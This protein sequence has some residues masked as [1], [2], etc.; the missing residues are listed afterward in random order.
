MTTALRCLRLTG[1]D[2]STLEGRNAERYR[3]AAWASLSNAGSRIVSMLLVVMSVHLTVPYL[4]TTRFGVWATFASMAAMLSLL[5][6]GIGNALVNRVAQAAAHGERHELQ[7]VVS[8]GSGLL[9]I[10]GF[11]A[12]ALLSIGA[13]AV[14]WERVF[15]LTDART[16]DE[17]R[18]AAVVFAV[19]FGINLFSTGLMRVLAG[20]QRMH[21]ANVVTGIAAALA[22]GTLWFAA[23][24]QAGVPWLIA[25]T[26]GLQSVVSLL[27]GVL[28]HRDGLWLR[29]GLGSAI[30]QEWR[31]LLNTGSLFMLLQLGTMVGWASDS[32]ILASLKGASEVAIYAVAVR[33]FQ[34]ASQPFAVINA[35]LWG[36][37]ADAFARRDLSFVRSTLKR[38]LALTLVGSCVA[39]GIL[40]IVAPTLIPAWTQRSL[41]VPGLL[42]L[43]L[44]VWTVLDSTGNAFGM[45][46]NGCGIVRQQVW[47]VTAFCCVVLPMKFWLG[48][49]WGA[50]GIVVATIVAYFVVVAG[51]YGVFLRAQVLRPIAMTS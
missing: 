22:C 40:L 20:Q 25:L 28:L 33:L 46:L 5:D 34:F 8:G 23:D 11:F 39:S 17:T 15:K 45:Y 18:T 30:Q 21:A 47:V 9:A 50:E 36:A 1:F 6:L 27:A 41:A 44:A 4:G 19:C 42:L 51:T 49:M 32:L 43:T 3:R 38:S 13:Y 35:P 37:Y 26:F 10:T 31:Y 7:R 14:P 48:G 12:A 24:K 16:I 2:T 29:R